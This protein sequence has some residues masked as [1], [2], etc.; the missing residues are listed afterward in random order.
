MQKLQST[1]P[2]LFTRYQEADAAK[3]CVY[4][5]ADEAACDAAY[6]AVEAIADA[7][8]ATPAGSAADAAMKAAVL[9][10]RGDDPSDLFHYRPADLSRFVKEVRALAQL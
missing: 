3:R 6:D 9:L 1:L 2:Q 4:A 7:I 5:D 8:L 10:A